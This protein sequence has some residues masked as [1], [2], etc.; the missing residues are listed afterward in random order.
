MVLYGKCKILNWRVITISKEDKFLN[1]WNETRK[2][3]KWKYILF[4]GVFLGG[5]GFSLGKVG[6][7]FFLER[8]LGNIAEYITTAI[9]FGVFFGTGTWFYTESRYK[10]YTANK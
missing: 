1:K 2:M 6:L 4:Q 5:I 10:K 3:G 7:D 8:E 9:I